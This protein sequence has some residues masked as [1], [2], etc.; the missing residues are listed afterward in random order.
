MAGV[1]YHRI[2]NSTPWL[3][4]NRPQQSSLKKTLQSYKT[5]AKRLENKLEQLSLK[6]RELES[7]AE[8]SEST[9]RELGL[10]QTTLSPRLLKQASATVTHLSIQVDIEGGETTPIITHPSSPPSHQAVDNA[11][12]QP[13]LRTKP[14]E[15]N[16]YHNDMTSLVATATSI[17]LESVELRLSYVMERIQQLTILYQENPKQRTPPELMFYRY[18]EWVH[19]NQRLFELNSQLFDLE[20]IKFDVQRKK[21]LAKQPTKK[22]YREEVDFAGMLLVINKKVSFSMRR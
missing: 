7:K 1:M 4:T 8:E 5:L 12:M 16:L 3:G 11:D 19:T 6:K 20:K 13:S 2:W 21:D 22:F 9:V 10:Q 18:K 14:E 15:T 17:L